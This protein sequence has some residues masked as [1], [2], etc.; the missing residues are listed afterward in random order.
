MPAST[1]V[2]AKRAARPARSPAPA[3]PPL[4]EL[5]R[6]HREMVDVLV[7]LEQLPDA[8]ER[9]GDAPAIRQAAREVV[10]FFAQG[11]QKHHQDEERLVFPGLLDSGDV[12][13]VQHV[14][15]LQQDHGWLEEDWIELAPLLEAVA[16]GS[17]STDTVVLRHI[18]DVFGT[19]YREHLALEES[20]VYPAARRLR[21][22]QAE[23]EA[24]RRAG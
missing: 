12:E 6:M 10:Q 11:A 13:M 24:A 17:G 4:E 2:S 16:L 22:R 9:D 21:A 3:L 20:V 7:K 5:D 1:T 23:A 18:V 15:R 19:L 8:I 14:R